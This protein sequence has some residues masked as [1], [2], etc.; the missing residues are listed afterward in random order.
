MKNIL[1]ISF[2]LT[3]TIIFAQ[4]NL[5]E[6]PH[7]KQTEKGKL[8]EAGMIEMASPWKSP[9]LAKSDL[10]VK[11]AKSFLANVPENEY[12]E[13]KPMEG[14]GYAGI[15]AYSYKDK[16]PRT[17]LQGKL[18]KKLEAGKEYCVTFHV[19]LADLSKYAC[20]YVGIALSDKEITANNSD[21]LSFDNAIVS[22]RLTVYEQQFYWIPVCGVYKAKGGEEYLTIGNFTPSEKLTT[23]KIKRPK[24][25]YKPQKYDAYYYID[26]VS[27]V[28]KEE[29]DKC[30]CDVVAGMENAKTVERDFT[31]DKSVQS[32][33][34]KIINTDG[35]AAGSQTKSKTVST[36]A[37]TEDVIDGMVINFNPKSFDMPSDGTSKLDKLIA[38]MK[39][40]KGT[41]IIVT[42]YI[43]S[44]ESDVD[45]L[46][47]KRVGTVYKYIV[48]QGVPKENV[49]RELGGENDIDD[50]D[51]LKNMRVEIMLDSQDEE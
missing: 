13:E 32:K 6:N 24:G 36:E 21:M 25:F 8:K 22:K 40:N 42:G 23:P 47:G 16:M 27:V 31:S 10:Y 12:G 29:V 15:L 9:T 1:F 35:S 48:S 28:A 11:D 26:N 49:G 3:S 44:S 20:N 41:K 38:Y 43:H 5:V 2:I 39:A 46:D 34:V 37:L 4:T 45:K 7:F 33:N 14:E 17:Y 50:E 18:S 30:N 19:S 51:K